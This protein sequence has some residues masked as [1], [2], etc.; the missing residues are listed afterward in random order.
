MLH[1]LPENDRLPEIKDLYNLVI[2]EGLL[3]SNA[4]WTPIQSEL[5][6]I[7]LDKLDDA[8]N[9]DPVVRRIVALAAR[10]FSDGRDVDA[11]TEAE[12]GAIKEKLLIEYRNM[13]DLEPEEWLISIRGVRLLYMLKEL[14]GVEPKSD[15]QMY[16]INAL[17]GAMYYYMSKVVASKQLG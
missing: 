14:S 4:I 5:L 1:P 13:T 10:W 15:I 9:N 11:L 2:T 16:M 6:G 7:D 3:T 12:L 8:Y 17:R